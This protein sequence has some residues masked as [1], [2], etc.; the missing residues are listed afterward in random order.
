MI[1]QRPSEICW[2]RTKWGRIR[3]VYCPPSIRHMTNVDS[4]RRMDLVR[5]DARRAEIVLGP[6]ASMANTTTMWWAEICGPDLHAPEL[7]PS[8]DHEDVRRSVLGVV[9]AAA[10]GR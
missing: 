6:W 5:W 1:C 3:L 8:D 2:R 4:A 10:A 9:R 7:P